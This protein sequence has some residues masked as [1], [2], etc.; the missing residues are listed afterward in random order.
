MADTGKG[1][2]VPKYKDKTTYY[3]SELGFESSY[4]VSSSYK[5]ILRLSPNDM[6]SLAESDDVE[7]ITDEVTVFSYKDA[8]DNELETQYIKVSTSDGYLLDC[9]MGRYGAEFDNLYVL[10]PSKHKKVVLFAENAKGFRLGNNTY[11]PATSNQ[12]LTA[13]IGSEENILKDIVETRTDSVSQVLVSHGATERVFDYESIYETV[14]NAI[15]EVLLDMATEPTGSIHYFPISVSEY[16]KLLLKGRPNQFYC[17]QKDAEGNKVENCPIIRD[18][19]LC[20]GSLYKNIDFPELAKILDHEKI[21]Y[22]QMDASKNRYVKKVWVNE[23]SQQKCFR[24]PDLRRMFLRA[25]YPDISKAGVDGNEVGYWEPDH[26]P[27][28]VKEMAEDNH[29]HCITSAFYTSR[30]VGGAA[31]AKTEADGTELLTESVGVLAP[32]CEVGWDA[33]PDKINK[34]FK[35]PSASVNATYQSNYYGSYTLC[36]PRDFNYQERN[37]SANVGLSSENITSVNY[38]PTN[39]SEISYNDLNEYESYLTQTNETYGMENAPEFFCGLPLI[40]I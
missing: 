23:Y 22:W 33:G 30:T 40:R 35:C 6:A 19:L 21:V 11:L 27:K 15:L 14:D 24:V 2:I 38:S 1:L 12:N 32:S 39:D 25:A 17:L 18:Y 29:T 37:L 20:D 9:R 26:R 31:V 13:L 3:Q 8:I 34:N 5:G 36:V 28:C 16:E 7:I 10:G 4:P